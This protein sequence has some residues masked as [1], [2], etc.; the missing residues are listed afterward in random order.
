MKR[1][2]FV[3]FFLPLF[4]LAFAFTSCE[5]DDN[6]V[7]TF[8]EAL[9]RIPDVEPIQGADNATVNVR[10]DRDRSYFRMSIE[11]TSGLNGV[12]NAWC[13]QLDEPLQRGVEHS[14]TKLYST[15][16][17]KFFNKL[18]YVINKRNVYEKQLEGLSWKDIQVVFWVILE[19]E[20]YNLSSIENRLPSA[21][22]GY[23]PIYVNNI[24]NDV[25]NNGGDFKPGLTDTR[26][27]YYEVQN[28][29]DGVAEE[30]GTAMARMNDD[31]NDLTYKFEV[32][33]WFTYL[34]VTPKDEDN[35]V[36]HYL[37]VGNI[38]STRVGEV[39]I[40]KDSDYLYVK[41]ILDSDYEMSNSE[42]HID[43][44]ER[45]DQGEPKDPDFFP[46]QQ[47]WA[48]GQYLSKEEHDPNATE[49]THIIDWDPS[50]D[51]EELYI[52]AHA[53]VFISP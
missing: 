45:D 47:P 5:L 1:G 16:R 15:D 19:T 10:N 11:N 53:D 44:A 48:F 52:V 17:D 18:S 46:V 21:V 41:Y 50:W 38:P 29:Q 8:D 26:L 31:P 23:N 30:L 20:N 42:V 25:K 4:L 35:K 6:P 3:K 32:H 39:E 51:D 37:Y 24:V 43:I 49:F 2:M 12:Y 27:V 9:E 14:G 13:V 40:W 33:E 22:D 7:K 34:V 28:N 36:T